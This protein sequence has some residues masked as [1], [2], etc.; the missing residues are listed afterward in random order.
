MA[1]EFEVRREQDLP[2]TPEQ[3]WDAVATGTGTGTGTGNLGWLHPMDEDVDEERA[4]KA[5]NAWLDH[6]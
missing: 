1:R 5:W 4:A 2:A 3:V 6:A